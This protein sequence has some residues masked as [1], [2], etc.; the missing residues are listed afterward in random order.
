MSSKLLLILI[1]GSYDEIFLNINEIEIFVLLSLTK[2]K[3]LKGTYYNIFS[4]NSTI[5]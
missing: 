2:Y 4:N 3:I 1:V 5:L